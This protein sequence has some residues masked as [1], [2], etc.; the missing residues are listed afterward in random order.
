[1]VTGGTRGLGLAI[2][3][4]LRTA[5]YLVA[6]CSRK[7][8]GELETLLAAPDHEKHLFFAPCNIGDEA[9]EERFFHQVLEWKGKELF[10]GLV[11]NAGV[12]GEGILATYPNVESERIIATNLLGSLRLSRL[13]LRV[14]LAQSEGGRILNIT[15]IIGL[16]GYTGLAAYAASK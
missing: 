15:S 14:L 12:A 3:R 6:T 16:R 7:L 9:D 13:A 11:N 10:W 5:G 8:T 2:L 1:M 4:D